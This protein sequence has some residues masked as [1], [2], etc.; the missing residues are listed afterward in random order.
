MSKKFINLQLFASITTCEINFTVNGEIIA[1][2]IPSEGDKTWS[3]ILN[4]VQQVIKPWDLPYNISDGK[5]I[6]LADNSTLQYEET[7]VLP[8]DNI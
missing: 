2:T 1:M 6:W 3:G 4:T 5:I 8:T 7:N